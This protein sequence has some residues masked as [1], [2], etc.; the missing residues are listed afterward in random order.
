MKIKKIKIEE[1]LPE[2][3]TRNVIACL[4]GYKKQIDAMLYFCKKN[5][6]WYV[7]H[8]N[9]DGDGDIPHNWKKISKEYNY[10]KSWV[11]NNPGDKIPKYATIYNKISTELFPIY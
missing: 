3:H 4:T 5:D 8:N 11:I 9:E 10:K 1:L 2:M 7:F 6:R